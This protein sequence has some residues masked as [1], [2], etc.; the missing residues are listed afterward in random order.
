MEEACAQ[1]RRALTHQLSPALQLSW[2]LT[3]LHVKLAPIGI[4]GS[5]PCLLPAH[6]W[7]EG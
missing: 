1:Y 3:S 7:K 5:T 2:M 4:F 6:D